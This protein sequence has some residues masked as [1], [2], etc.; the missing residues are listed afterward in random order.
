MTQAVDWIGL[1]NNTTIA[2]HLLSY[3]IPLMTNRWKKAPV[4]HPY[5]N[6]LHNSLH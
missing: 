2:L 1:F 3:V 4:I 5:Q 6:K